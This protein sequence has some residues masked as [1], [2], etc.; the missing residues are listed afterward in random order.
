MQASLSLHTTVEESRQIRHQAH[1][2]WYVA[3]EI[4][5]KAYEPQHRAREICASSR[6]LCQ[7]ARSLCDGSRRLLAHR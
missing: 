5:A 1:L 2:W 6:A 3:T 7:E 4:R